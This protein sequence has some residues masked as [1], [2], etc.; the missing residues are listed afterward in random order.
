MFSGPLSREIRCSQGI[1]RGYALWGAP[2]LP[3]RPA[4]VRQGHRGRGGGGRGRPRGAGLRCWAGDHRRGGG[5][6]AQRWLVM[7]MVVVVVMGMVMMMVVVMV[8]MV[9]PPG[10][11]RPGLC[12]HGRAAPGAGDGRRGF[13]PVPVGPVPSDGAGAAG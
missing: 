9:E 3:A 11:R 5:R 4:D 12:G 13:H 1:F 8:M 6:G 10:G 2:L 7:M